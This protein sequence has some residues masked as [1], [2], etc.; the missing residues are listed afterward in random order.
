[1]EV[2]RERKR[3]ESELKSA[4]FNSR[5]KVVAGCPIFLDNKG[6]IAQLGERDT[7]SVEVAGSS[8]AGSTSLREAGKAGLSC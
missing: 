1:M 4:H 6:A 2:R 3:V 5:Q 8:P 7:G